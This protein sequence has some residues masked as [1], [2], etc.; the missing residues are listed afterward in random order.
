MTR[1][2]TTLNPWAAEDTANSRWTT[3]VLEQT[4]ASLF[5]PVL[6]ESSVEPL[7]ATGDITE[8]VERADGS[9]EVEV[10]VTGAWSDGT[11]VT[12]G[13]LEF[14]FDTVRRLGLGGQWSRTWFPE[15]VT[16]ITA[17]EEGVRILFATRPGLEVWPFGPGTAPILPAH[18]WGPLVEAVETAEDLYALDGAGAPAAGR[19]VVTGR[20]EGEEIRLGPNPE[21]GD[22][23]PAADEAV[24]A[25]YPDVE[26]AIDALVTG[27]IDAI[28]DPD[29]LAPEVVAGAADRLDEGELGSMLS[30]NNGFR[31]LAFNLNR[32]VTGNLG[33]RQAVDLIATAYGNT[34]EAGGQFEA[35]VSIPSAN[36]AWFDGE[37]ATRLRTQPPA[38]TTD[39]I[40]RL[41][42]TLT[43]AG[44]SWSSP[45]TVNGDTVTPGTGLTLSGAAIP[46]L[47]VL[48]PSEDQVRLGYAKAVVS[49]LVELGFPVTLKEAPLDEVVE[50]VFTP[51]T[52][53]FA[54]DMYLAGWNLGRPEFPSHHRAFFGTPTETRGQ[55]NN[56]G[57]TSGAFDELLDTYAA[58]RDPAQA[59]QVVWAMEE[60]LATQKPYVFLYTEPI[61]EL[62]RADRV[63]FPFT[64]RLGGIQADGGAPAMVEPVE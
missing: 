54:F 34:P 40:E 56:T 7:L 17:E 48:S 11:P 41:V 10:A 52:G 39:R 27:E 33:F 14:T 28:I 18:H 63:A 22:T 37:A 59:R 38:S 30:E 36:L 6:D 53:G 57:F 64:T 55:N 21:W 31:F 29:G 3:Y 44:F 13:D 43:G 9:W 12:A 16:A 47:E 35:G 60:I 19:F 23:A 24:Y 26:A 25:V 5:T 4:R 20:T 50:Q 45:P 15:Q 42:A 2:V 1:D 51:A 49:G 62:Y 46:P 58:T 61:S 8:P 32:P